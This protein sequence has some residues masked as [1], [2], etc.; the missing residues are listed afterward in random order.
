[1]VQYVGLFHLTILSRKVSKYYATSHYCA[2]CQWREEFYKWCT[3]IPISKD[4]T[5]VAARNFGRQFSL[6]YFSTCLF[7]LHN[8]RDTTHA[9]WIQCLNTISKVSLL[10]T[11]S[12]EMCLSC[13]ILVPCNK[14]KCYHKTCFLEHVYYNMILL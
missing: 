9:S 4:S 13:I 12:Y 7:S 8:L 1:M 5:T 10:Y 6:C 3:K 11:V 2:W 14:H